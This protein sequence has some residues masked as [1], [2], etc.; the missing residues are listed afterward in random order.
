MVVGL[1]M[2]AALQQLEQAAGQN[3]AVFNAF[4][5]DGGIDKEDLCN[6]SLTGPA[7]RPVRCRRLCM[8]GYDG[9]LYG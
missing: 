8:D 4:A 2:L 1:I 5:L 3:I 6:E 7:Y 9:C